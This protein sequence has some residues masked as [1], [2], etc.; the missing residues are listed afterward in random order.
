MHDG[1]GNGK[2]LFHTKRILGIELFV[3]IGQTN[4]LQG[5]LDCV[6]LFHIPKHRKDFQVFRSGQVW[7]KSRR[8]DQAAHTGQNFPGCGADVLTENVQFAGTGGRQAQEHF[9]GGGFPSSV[10]AQQAVNP[11]PPDVNVQVGNA[12]LASIEFCQSSRLNNTVIHWQ[13]LLVVCDIIIA[14]SP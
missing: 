1:Q 9:H 2:P 13:Y 12:F 3:P 6:M 11:P 7:I 5:V 8:L 4:Q 10:A 14:P